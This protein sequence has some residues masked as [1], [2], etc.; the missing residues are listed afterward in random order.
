MLAKTLFALLALP[1]LVHAAQPAALELV[2]GNMQVLDRKALAPH[3]FVV[4][5]RDGDARP[6]PHVALAVTTTCGEFD[7]RKSLGIDTD[8]NGEVSLTVKVTETTSPCLTTFRVQGTQIQKVFQ[9]YI[10]PLLISTGWQAAYIEPGSPLY[11]YDTSKGG[12]FCRISDARSLVSPFIG[13]SIPSPPPSSGIQYVTIIEFSDC[14]PGAEVRN[15]LVLFT[16]PQQR[17][18][19]LFLEDG[20][21]RP[22]AVAQ[23]PKLYLS[24]PGI[25][26]GGPTDLDGAVN[27]KMTFG[28]T[29]APLTSNYQ[30]L[31][32]AGPAENGWGMS[33]VQHRDVLF[34]V[35]YAY[36]DQGEP[37]WYVMPGGG[38]NADKTA[39]SGPLY[40]PRGSPYSSYDAGAF[41]AGAPVGNATLTFAS[42]TDATLDFDINGH[43]GRKAITRQQFGPAEVIPGNRG[44]MWWGGESQNGWGVAVLQ[45]YASLFSIWFTYDAGG[46]P[47]WFVVPA[48]A[49]TDINTWEGKLYR[50]HGSAWLTGYDAS[51]LQMSE[52]GNVR[53]RFPPAAGTFEYSVEGRAGSVP[54]VRQPF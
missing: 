46:L 33:I 40:A 9:S 18:Q 10:R 38:W 24:Y 31:W 35:I 50:P 3:P 48:G 34:S 16:V 2:H 26:D 43:S 6:M 45:Q 8:E 28:V 4:R 54:I 39:Y 32:W 42:T 7:G 30:D 44:D 13:E 14:S 27:G 51:K 22:V 12:P 36:D 52:V 49:W 21:W 37:R 25:V 17:G 11:Y 41:T 20:D 15:A 19:F 29:S 5:V 23:P 1:C 53:L 47:T